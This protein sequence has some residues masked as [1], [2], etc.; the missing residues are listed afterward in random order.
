VKRSAEE[1]DAAYYE[2]HYEDPESCAAS[3]ED[4]RVLGDFVFSYLRYLRVD[5]DS[6]LDLGCGLG[7]WRDVVARHAPEATYHGVEVSPY[8]CEKLGWERGSVIDYE[9]EPADLV[10][11]Q[12]V[13]QYL[14]AREA[15]KAIEQLYALTKT[16]LYLEVLTQRDLE[17][18][19][20]RSRTDDAVYIRKGSWYWRALAGK[21]IAVGGGLFLP[22]DTDVPLFELE[23][24]DP[25]GV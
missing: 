5:V 17:T 22:V 12:G 24:L 16:A 2:R 13:L 21:F 20:D 9:G 6:A 25:R 8:L 23:A 10:I 3:V 1:F 7:H 4:I 18:A 19:C 15:R 14:D 11:C